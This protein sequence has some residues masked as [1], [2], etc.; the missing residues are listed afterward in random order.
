MKAPRRSVVCLNFCP[1]SSDRKTNLYPSSLLW[2]PAYGGGSFTLVIEMVW[3]QA[4]SV[5]GQQ[6]AIRIRYIGAPIF[7]HNGHVAKSGKEK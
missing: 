6:Y 7:G 3:H 4:L 2:L 5:H 1:E